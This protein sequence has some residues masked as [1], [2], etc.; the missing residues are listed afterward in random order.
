MGR[1]DSWPAM[2]PGVVASLRYSLS[3]KAT[4]KYPKWRTV[5]L[6][7]NL[8]VDSELGSLASYL[9]FLVTIRLSRL[10]LEILACDGRTDNKDHYYSWP[11]HCGGQLIS[12]LNREKALLFNCFTEIIFVLWSNHCCTMVNELWLYHGCTTV[13][14]YDGV[15]IVVPW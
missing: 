11:P 3:E 2:V 8:M 14:L 12:S 1:D 10:V 7:A 6:I 15:T 4:Q 9:S 5:F 13:R